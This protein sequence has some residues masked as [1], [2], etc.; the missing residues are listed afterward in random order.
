M[1][2]KNEQ[3]ILPM[4]QIR[5]MV[6]EQRVRGLPGVDEKQIQPA[7]LDLKLGHWAGRL[8]CS[9]LPHGRD[10]TL[11]LQEFQ[12]EQIEI[13]DGAVLEV[14]RPYLVPIME[15]IDLPAGMRAMTNPR[16][17]TGRL[18][19]FTRVITEHARQFDTVPE[20][21]RGGMFLEIVSKSFTVKI[22]GEMSMNQVR[23]VRGNPRVGARE[24]LEL[25]EQDALAL[26]ENEPVALDE[27]A[28]EDGLPLTV[29]LSGD[30]DGIVGYR[31]KR[32]SR[33]LDLTTAET[34]GQEDFWEPV[35]AERGRR[36]VLEPEEFHILA[37]RESV[38]IPPSMAAEM[39]ALDPHAGEFRTHYAGFFDPGFGYEAPGTRAVMEI[40]AHD[41]PFALE[42]GQQVCRLRFERMLEVPEKTYGAQAGSSYQGQGIRLSKHFAGENDNGE[43]RPG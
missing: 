16:S 14:N 4:Q 12:M 39:V 20:G 13:R 9:F 26:L 33:L 11:S 24:L 36:L 38:R 31:A 40:R 22:R 32:N 42:H 27:A 1:T 34:H 15:M 3:G 28:L 19:I 5:K 10:M 25:H 18:D 2:S 37:S 41:V 30:A 29:D 6:R 43:N 21:Y 8:R 7:S 23:F 35:R 17:S